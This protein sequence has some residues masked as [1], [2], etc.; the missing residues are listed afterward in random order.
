MTKIQNENRFTFFGFGSD[1][2]SKFRNFGNSDLEF[3]SNFV[4]RVSDFKNLHRNISMLF[5]GPGFAFGAQ[6]L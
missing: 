2:T 5:R 1:Y 6:G 3:V 4:L